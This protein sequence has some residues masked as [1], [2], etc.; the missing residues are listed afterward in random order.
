MNSHIRNF[1][2]I[3]H[4]DHGKSTLA[5]RILEITGTIAPSKMKE[6]V[7][8]KM[9]LERERGITI[10]SSPVK[11]NYKAKDGKDYIFNLIDTPGHVDFSYEV[12]RSLVACEGA[13][14][15]V[16]ATQGVEAQTLA[17]FYL[18]KDLNLKI[19]PVINKIDLPAADPEKVKG[20]IIELLGLGRDE[21]LSISAKRGTG[22]EEVLEAV[23]RKIPPPPGKSAEPLKALIFDSFYDTYRGVVCIFRIMQGQIKFADS[24]KFFSSGNS[25]QINELGIFTPDMKA[26]S[27]LCAG[28][29]GYLTAQIKNIADT[30][31]GDTITSEKNPADAP[32]P[33]YKEI[34]PMVYC[35]LYPTDNANY[36][37]LRE[38]LSK[39][40]LN[41]ASL[42]FEPETS[43]ALGFGFRC[44]FLG[45][46]H[47]DIIQ[48]RLEREFGF[49][50]IATAPNV[51]YHVLDK[52][53]EFLEIDNPA[54]F[55]NL[56]DV[57]EVEEPVVKATIFTPTQFMGVVMDLC[58]NKRGL[59]EKMD[60]LADDRV[61]IHQVL[62]LSEI[63]IDFFDLLKTYTKGY[64][65]LDYEFCGYKA[66]D[67]TKLEILIAG[68]P[69]DALSSIV[70]KDKAYYIAKNVVERLR[71]VIPRQQYEVA[72]QAQVGG[73]IIARETIKAYRKDVISK[74]YGGDI[75]RKRK[76][77]EK[78]KKGKRRM[79]SIG[80]IDIPQE[81]FLS[82]IGARKIK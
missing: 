9:D 70:H 80:N 61:V 52:K 66:A 40:K 69:V 1:C 3:A 21:I 6:Q 28:E 27:K 8:D 76:L 15:V 59:V 22:I 82:A 73:R 13:L 81:A 38:A 31:V 62:P 67:L 34:K 12:S 16:D 74:C 24:V 35:G 18:A 45:L 5:D 36:T 37:L 4:I 79:K 71:E 56:S 50:L 2:I 30:K 68:K 11:I 41:D 54:L 25:F 55:P 10:K 17:N 23:A 47:M 49:E 72:I 63:I 64:A 78:Q 29:V 42:Y 60:Y 44:G 75:T 7:L 46:L 43:N 51:I 57:S 14:L 20:E 77:L 32:L 48:E 26:V 33:G 53:N 65:S 58:K 19:I 39:L